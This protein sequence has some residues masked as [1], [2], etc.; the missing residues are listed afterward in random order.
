MSDRTG[1][2]RR[3]LFTGAALASVAVASDLALSRPPEQVI[4]CW[5]GWRNNPTNTGT[6]AW[7]TAHLPVFAENKR[8]A[9]DALVAYVSK[10][11]ITEPAN[12]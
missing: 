1:I 8:A 6:L 12:V 5:S 9:Q 3:T 2:T 4:V 10:L 11:I 7:Y